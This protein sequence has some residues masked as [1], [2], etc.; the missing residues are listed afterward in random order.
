MVNAINVNSFANLFDCTTVGLA[1]DI[2]KHQ[3]KPSLSVT[4]PA[5]A[6]Q[7]FRDVLGETYRVLTG[8]LLLLKNFARGSVRFFFYFRLNLM[9]M[10]TNYYNNQLVIFHTNRTTKCLVKQNRT[11]SEG[12]SC[13]KRFKFLPQQ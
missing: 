10:F 9:S 7:L 8:R 12:W 11:K 6:C 2:L 4:Q 1:A 13:T 5:G 3:H